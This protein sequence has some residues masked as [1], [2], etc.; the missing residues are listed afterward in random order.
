MIDGRK[1]YAMVSARVPRFIVESSEG[2]LVAAEGAPKAVT[3]SLKELRK[4][5]HWVGMELQAGPEGMVVD[6]T[7]GRKQ[8][9]WLYDLWLAGRLLESLG[10]G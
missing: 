1:Y 8:N 6:R 10:E 9:M 3:E 2:K 5:K 7:T 4:A